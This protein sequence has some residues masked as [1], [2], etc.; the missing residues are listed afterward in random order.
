MLS[1]CSRWI[2][3]LIRGIF[4]HDYSRLLFPLLLPIAPEV[5]VLAHVVERPDVEDAL[6]RGHFTCF[7]TVVHSK[8]LE[9]VR[10]WL[11]KND[12]GGL[13][14]DDLQPIL[15]DKMDKVGFL[16]GGVN[17]VDPEPI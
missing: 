14:A 3:G 9:K 4:L 16:T 10:Q 1:W 17:V 13:A 6:W 12:R 5:L 15:I 8:S 2:Y 11:R 7:T